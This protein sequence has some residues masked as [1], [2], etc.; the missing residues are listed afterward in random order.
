M[1]HVEY[2][3]CIEKLPS[4]TLHHIRHNAQEAIVAE[5]DGPNFGYYVDELYLCASELR[6]RA[7]KMVCREHEH[8]GVLAEMHTILK[9]A[10][11]DSNDMVDDL[12]DLVND[13]RRYGVFGRIQKVLGNRR[14]R[15]AVPGVQE[16]DLRGL[17]DHTA[18]GIRVSMQ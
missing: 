18:K 15:G 8:M 6:N 3:A 11:Y 1:N 12:R 16:N 5:P 7:K 9:A 2:Q 10:G 4:I 17:S 14:I 13:S